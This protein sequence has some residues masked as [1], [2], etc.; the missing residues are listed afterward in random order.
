[1][2]NSV[3]LLN[4]EKIK[5]QIKEKYRKVALTPHGS[6]NFPVGRDGLEALGYDRELIE[7]F[8]KTVADSFCGVGNPFSLGPVRRG[9]TIL[10]VG[11]GAGF[12]SLAAAFQA[13]PSGKIIGLDLTEEMIQRARRNQEET[14]LR[15]VEFRVGEAEALPFDDST[16]DLLISNGTY[17]LTPDKRRAMAE[18]FRVL[19]PGGR[20]QVCDMSL[21]ESLPEETIS[22]LDA[23]SQ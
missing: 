16:F 5:G 23:W 17:N 4:P 2:I 1:M 12:D 15:N 22:S 19:K 6:F 7:A 20:L 9:E 21:A 10:D 3:C 13:G 11:C 8:P 18:A 14:G